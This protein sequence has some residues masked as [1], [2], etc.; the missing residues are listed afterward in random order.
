M[1]QLD[2][3]SIAISSQD[4]F[5]INICLAFLMFGV[6]LEIKLVDFKYLFKKPK[7]VGIGLISQLI[8]LPFLSFLLVILLKPHAGIAL[9]VLLVA[10]C[11]GG[12]VSNF[13]VHIFNGNRALSVSLTSITTVIAF[14]YTPAS[15]W[16]WGSLYGPTHDLL[17]QFSISITQLLWILTQLILIPLAIGMLVN[18]YFEGIKNKIKNPIRIISLVL[19]LG[20]ILGAV[21]ANYENLASYLRIVFFLVLIHN[22]LAY[23]AGWL[24][25]GIFRL[26][27][28]DQ[29][30]ITLE[31]GI[32]NS[33]LGLIIILNFYEGM[34]SMLLVT[35]WWGVWHLVSGSILASWWAYR[36]KKGE[37]H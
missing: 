3:I 26:S 2:N 10:S 9:G 17:R 1:D 15:L 7:P 5:L 21:F 37:S 23:T 16:F 18:H 8:L 33:G 24:F 36:G 27:K 28:S 22:G 6:A 30:T 29:R 4:L 31:T 12:N 19:F 20:I 35:A 11:P 32:Q 13:L 34:P 25:S 14:A